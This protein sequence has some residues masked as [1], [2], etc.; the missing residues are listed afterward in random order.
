MKKIQGLIIISL[1][2][3]WT[4]NPEKKQEETTP[5]YT[6]DYTSLSKHNQQPDWFQDAKLGIYFHSQRQI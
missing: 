2:L 6:A 1:L 3:I 5:K 4:C